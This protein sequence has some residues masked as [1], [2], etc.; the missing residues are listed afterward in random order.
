MA[1]LYRK[2]GIES[3]LRTKSQPSLSNPNA[4][5]TTLSSWAFLVTYVAYADPSG[6]S[7]GRLTVTWTFPYIESNRITR[8]CVPL[9]TFP[10]HLTPR[11]TGEAFAVNNGVFCNSAFY[12]FWTDRLP[13]VT[14]RPCRSRAHS[15]LHFRSSARKNRDLTHLPL[16]E[17]RVLLKSLVMKANPPRLKQ[18]VT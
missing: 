9:S 7:V 12:G 18:R 14:E 17:R 6:D 8:T 15:L 4:F 5:W 10:E 3:S 11:A 16:I 13:S 2:L 1:T